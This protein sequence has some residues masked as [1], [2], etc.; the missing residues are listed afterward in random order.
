MAGFIPRSS[1][2]FIRKIDIIFN[3]VEITE[4]QQPF[5]QNVM[6]YKLS[7]EAVLLTTANY[8]LDDSGRT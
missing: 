3:N 8:N 5:L 2:N 1:S 7:S 4:F 6:D